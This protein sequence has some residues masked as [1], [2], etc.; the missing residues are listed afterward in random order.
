MP[1]KPKQPDFFSLPFEVHYGDDVRVVTYE[2]KSDVTP[3][4]FSDLKIVHKEEG[5]ISGLVLECSN[6]TG[7]ELYC[8]LANLHDEVVPSWLSFVEED[9]MDMEYAADY[10]VTIKDKQISFT[11]LTEEQ[12]DEDS[13]EYIDLDNLD[14]YFE[15][16]EI[17]RAHV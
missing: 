5:S 4:K 13:D 1:K 15:A 6:N 14:H 11:E 12:E 3:K 10:A 8:C 16:L 7:S 2:F 17:G 9:G